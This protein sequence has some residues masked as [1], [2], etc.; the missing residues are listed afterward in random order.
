[1]RPEKQ[2][3]VEEV[4]RQLVGA[5]FGLVVG[6]KGLSVAKLTALREQLRAAGT[7][8]QV[9]KNSFLKLASD[10]SGKPLG[11]VVDG[12]TALV[13]GSGDVVEAAKTLVKFGVANQALVVRGGRYPGGLLSGADVKEL[14]SLP[15]RGVL[16]GQ[17]VGLLA[18]P[19]SGLAG[20]LRQKVAS[21][22]Y[23]LRAIE[24]KKS[25]S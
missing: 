9:V 7:R 16:L 14:S 15:P 22:L 13:S 3:I 12:P 23:A 1:M 18:S 5:E 24:D 25:K 6:Y 21:L 17:M 4:T 2:A 8:L 20:V 10:R 11:P 19:M